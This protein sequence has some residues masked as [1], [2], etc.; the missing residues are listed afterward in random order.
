MA[1][2]WRNGADENLVECN[3]GGSELEVDGHKNGR[4]ELTNREVESEI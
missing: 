1:R 3:V 2:K 4:R